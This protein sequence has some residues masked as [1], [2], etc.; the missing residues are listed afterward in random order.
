MER[1]A[2]LDELELEL[3]IVRGVRGVSGGACTKPARRTS[4]I[5][6]RPHRRDVYWGMLRPLDH[7]SPATQTATFGLG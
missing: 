4:T 5:S 1:C 7:T 2:T 3:A 6:N